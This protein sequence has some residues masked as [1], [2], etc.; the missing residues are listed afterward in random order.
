M[1]LCVTILEKPGSGAGVT[2]SD[3]LSSKEG[4]TEGK[5]M[6]E[7]EEKKEY[8]RSYQKAVRREQEILDEIQQLR[9][10][11]MFPSVANDGMPKGSKQSDLSEYVVRLD[12]LIKKLKEERFEKIKLMDDI[13]YRISLLEDKDE[14]RVLKLRY[15][16]G[17]KWKEIEEAL[18]YSHRSVHRLHSKSLQHLVIA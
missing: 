11:K 13:L 12:N 1:G 8:L 16:K 18:G 5:R 3:A 14:Q 10:D 6:S 2:L 15:I 4:K 7:N 9:M 17:L